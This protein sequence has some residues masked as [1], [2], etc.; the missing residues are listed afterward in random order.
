M[1]LSSFREDG[2]VNLE[3]Y[4]RQVERLCETDIAG[5]VACGS[6]GEFS[7]M[8]PEQN[9]E[10]LKYTADLVKGRK[11]LVGGATAGDLG[12][13]LR[14]LSA[15]EGRG[16]D[17]AF[18]APPY[19]LP[20]GDED[21]LDF[22]QELNDRSGGLPIV[23]YQ[24]P[25]FT[26]G[27]SMPVLEKLL[28]LEHVAGLK[29]S[30]GNMR[31]II[32]QVYLRN[33]RRPDFAVLTG[34]DECL[35]PSLAVG[36]NG[37]FTALGGVFPELVAALYRLAGTED[38]LAP[39]MAL[40]QMV[41]IAETAPFPLGYKLLAEAAGR[42]DAGFPRQPVSADRLGILKAR[43]KKE[44]DACLRAE[45]VNTAKTAVRV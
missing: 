15:M 19:Y 30:T 17:G 37:S 4:E 33:T 38:A 41:N 44:Y 14:Y 24:I 34:S 29:N 39:Q 9:V 22:Y 43:I 32:R 2:A 28:E 35:L 40:V 5:L 1:L 23:L 13:S 16:Y 18:V 42:F 8:S 31:E 45:T 3:V 25:Q 27:I 26:S 36:A 10:L 12:T 21:I 20:L 6:T 11:K 7:V